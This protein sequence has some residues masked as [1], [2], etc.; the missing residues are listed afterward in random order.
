MISGIDKAFNYPESVK[1]YGAGWGASKS[2]GHSLESAH[3]G[4]GSE[5]AGGGLDPE[6]MLLARK[7]RE[8]G[9]YLQ[10][11][12]Y[13]VWSKTVGKHPGRGE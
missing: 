6:D 11:R 1:G 8:N 7:P 10:K 12:N 2:A 9:V 5:G 3:A 13:P 4:G